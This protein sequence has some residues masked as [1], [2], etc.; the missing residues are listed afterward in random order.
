M[1]T[2]VNSENR[3]VWAPQPVSVTNTAGFSASFIYQATGTADGVTF[4]LQD[5][6][7]GTAALGTGG[8]DLGYNGAAGTAISPSA[9]IQ[10]NLYQTSNG[11]PNAGT[12][13]E[14]NGGLPP[15]YGN[16]SVLP[17]VL[18]SG[19]KILVTLAYNGSANTLQENLVD[20]S[21]AASYTITYT[22]VNFQT[23]LG[24]T[25]A[26]IGFTGSTGG[27]NA[28]QNV[29]NLSYNSGTGLAYVNVITVPAGATSTLE[30]AA[31][32]N[33]NSVQAGGLIIGAAGTLDVVPAA[34]LSPNSPYTV[35][36]AGATN[37]SGEAVFDIAKNGTGIG[38]LSLGALNDGGSAS[39]LV[40]QDGGTTTL[41]ATAT[42]LVNGTFVFVGSLGGGSTPG[43]LALNAPGALGTLAFVND[44]T[45]STVSLGASQTFGTITGG[46]NVVLN[47]NT[48][49]IGSS[50]NLSNGFLGTISDGTSPGAVTIG[51]TGSF[52]LAGSDSYTG[53]TTINSGAT[54][55]LGSA[56]A[57][58]SGNSVVANGT[59][60]LNYS[61][62]VG[63]LNGSGGVVLNGT[64]LTIGGSANLSS[65][66]SG[67]I[68][69]GSA[70][71]S[72]TVAGTGPLSLYGVNTYTGL[73][74][75][76]A[77][78]TLNV[79]G[80]LGSTGAVTTSGTVNFEA[81]NSGGI[82]ARTKGQLTINA[83]GVVTVGVAATSATRT[84]LTVSGLSIA[85]AA[86]AYTGVLDLANNDLDVQGGNLSTITSQIAQGYAN[87]T[88]QG[89]GGI[90]SS[91][92]A[93]DSTHLT[94]LGVIENTIDGGTTQLYG[95]TTPMGT[96]DGAN[97]AAT[98]I[99]VKYTYYGDANLDGK[100]D[101]SDYSK[102]DAGYAA[103]G[104]L[105]GWANGDF[106]YDGVIDGSDYT[107][108]DNAF[109]S[110]GVQ[111]TASIASPS[112]QVA[113][114]S[115]VP[116]PATFSLLAIGV[117]GL[118]GRR[119]RPN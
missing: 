69:D 48:L 26:Y 112:A 78:A 28:A 68:S 45:G 12:V 5:D 6:P 13:F 53:L 111:I 106:N 71:G 105:I 20:Q 85:G 35:T 88:W 75:V 41:A 119:R 4:D 95:A 107:L 92:A 114:S 40:F 82:Y 101:G 97:P 8:G 87:G 79:Y 83:G 64:T 51:G 30:D 49:T 15:A 93:V 38:T 56:T 7:R 96:F 14:T 102:I 43:N 76:N 22:G 11:S 70:S 74:T 47:G 66:F 24:A 29:S 54:L 10:I 90:R 9:S 32:L 21:T 25:T 91:V 34:S 117:A 115:A 116:E 89:S 100:V 94:A 77:G 65:T 99:L 27:Y 58:V 39:T 33:G 72:L 36:M 3:S 18:N 31:F 50:N 60:N 109:N 84:F 104:T 59:L 67:V 62:T 80:S 16:N 108:I 52:T 98:D 63:S 55:T 19:D 110:Q 37:V 23:I 44:Q 118:L 2:A 17:V 57:L 73:T 61:Q 1:T 46:G 86:G 81:N 113:G 42:S 103:G